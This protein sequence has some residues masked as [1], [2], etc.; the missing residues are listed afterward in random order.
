[1]KKFNVNAEVHSEEPVDADDGQRLFLLEAAELKAAV[2]A[3]V[4]GVFTSVF[5]SDMLSPENLQFLHK[6]L[7]AMLS[8]MNTMTEENRMKISKR[9]ESK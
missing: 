1:M 9:N 3:R 4:A 5:I 2:L 8:V 6:E 7:T